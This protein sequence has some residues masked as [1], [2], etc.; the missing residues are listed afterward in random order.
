MADL[1]KQ[2]FQGFYRAD[3]TFHPRTGIHMANSLITE[4]EVQR[5]REALNRNMGVGPTGCV[6]KALKALSPY[7]AP[8]LSPI[9]NLSLQ[10]SQISDD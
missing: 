4:S 5:A 8:T 10:T 9:L 7:I 2:I 1:L 6:P 3:P